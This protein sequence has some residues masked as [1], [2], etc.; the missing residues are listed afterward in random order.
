VF[1]SGLLPIGALLAGVV[2]EL[3]STE[4]AVWV[5]VILGL[6]APVFLLPLR[7]LQVMPPPADDELKA[8]QA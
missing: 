4:I 7:H 2:A 6:V 1:T 5:G 8:V 3:A